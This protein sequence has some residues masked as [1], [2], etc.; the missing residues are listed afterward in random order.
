MV[1][2]HKLTKIQSQKV[3]K[4]N[5]ELPYE[6][7]SSI[8]GG[9]IN[10]FHWDINGM[11][12][13]FDLNGQLNG[14]FVEFKA[15]LKIDPEKIPIYGV[16]GMKASILTNTNTGAVPSENFEDGDFHSAF[17]TGEISQFARSFYFYVKCAI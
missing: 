16:R 17:V 6:K 3:K 9:F 8:S 12:P 11:R 15:S 2:I 1:A 10:Q 7:I 14:Q 5:F 13:G 4:T